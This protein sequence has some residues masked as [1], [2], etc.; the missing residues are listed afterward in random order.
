MSYLLVF[1]V[2]FFVGW[3]LGQVIDVKIGYTIEGKDGKPKFY[4]IETKST[5][6]DK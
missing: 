5:E 6:D 2:F 4:G 3:A 1:L